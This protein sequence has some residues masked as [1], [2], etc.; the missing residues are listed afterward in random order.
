M[1]HEPQKV[2]KQHAYCVPQ[3]SSSSSCSSC[4]SISLCTASTIAV[5]SFLVGV[6]AGFHCRCRI[7]I[8]LENL[9][10]LVTRD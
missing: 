8:A 2:H 7:R 9:L 10:I 4:W 1:G 3:S 5:G 6:I